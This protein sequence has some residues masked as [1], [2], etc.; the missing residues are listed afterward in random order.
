[1]IVTDYEIGKEENRK[2]KKQ[3]TK[4]KKGKSVHVITLVK[5]F[6]CLASVTK[7]FCFVGRKG[8]LYN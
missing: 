3:Q 8:V 4:K 7:L 6:L 5:K 2:K 1:M